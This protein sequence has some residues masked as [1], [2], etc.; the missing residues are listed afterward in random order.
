MIK[1]LGEHVE[2]DA[3]QVRGTVAAGFEGVREAFAEVLGEQRHAPEAQLVVHVDGHRVVDLWGGPGTAADTLTGLYSITK[4]AA[5]LVVALLVQDGVLD[6]DRTVASYWPEFGAEGK[7]RLT[8]RELLAHRSGAVGVD[9]GFTL[10]ELADD[11]LSAA[12][13]AGHRP[14]W[15]PGTAYGYH[16]F[17]IG[18]LT[19]EVVRRVTGR[20]LQEVYEERIRAPYGLDFHLGLPE[21]LEER[22]AQVLPLEPTEE[23]QR[24]LLADAAA[25]DSVPA[26]AFNQNTTPPTDLV[27]FANTRAVRALGPASSGGVGTAR[28]VAGM[29][30]AAISEVDGRAPLLAP[31]TITEFARVSH[32]GTD[33]VTGNDDV[34]GLGFESMSTRYAFLG[35]EAFGHSGATGSLAF[36]D[37]ASG[38]AYAYTR[39]RFGFPSGFGAGLENHRLAEAV[40]RA[41]K[42][43]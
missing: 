39:R 13:L 26:V 2:H 38:V 8:L 29:Y 6:L 19:G 10:A 21:A 34:F 17:V 33:V 30:A 5:H 15:E 11:R 31:H 27:A 32:R 37:P 16:A 42:G 9:G 14:F 23:E 3:D 22:Y 35:P 40:A 18:A 4:G 20:S 24:L 43:R 12:R 7:D 28:G 25:P 1:L 36:A 41:A